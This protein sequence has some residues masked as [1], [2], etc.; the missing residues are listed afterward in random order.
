MMSTYGTGD[1]VCVDVGGLVIEGLSPPTIYGHDWRPG[2]VVRSIGG[3]HY[4]VSL[5]SGQQVVTVRDD[6]LGQREPDGGGPKP[7]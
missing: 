6:R 1:L 3:K 7:S 4:E 5:E 2:V